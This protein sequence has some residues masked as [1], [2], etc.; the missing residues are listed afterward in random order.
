MQTD[1]KVDLQILHKIWDFM[2]PMTVMLVNCLHLMQKP[3]TT[4]YLAEL[5]N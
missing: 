4:E 5:G 1:C 2:K 3:L